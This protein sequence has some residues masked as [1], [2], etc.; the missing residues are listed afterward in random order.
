LRRRYAHLLL[1]LLAIALL[2]ACSGAK[3]NSELELI[4]YSYESTI[5]WGDFAGA[6]EMVDPEY[7]EKH[8]LTATDWERFKQV[9]VAGYRSGGPTV[10]EEGKIGQV[11]EVE[12]INVH[13]QTPR[14]IMDRQVWQW[15]PEAKRWWLKTGLPDITRR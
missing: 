7:R 11:V 9:R 6:W 4:L 12:V 15:D 13:T 3:K 14:T 8:P 5:R 10:I 2:S 1:S